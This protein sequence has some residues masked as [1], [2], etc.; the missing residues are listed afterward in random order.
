M[1]RKWYRISAKSHKLTFL[2]SLWSRKEHSIGRC[3]LRGNFT[4]G[5]LGMW[6]SVGHGAIFTWS[7]KKHGC[8][9]WQASAPLQSQG[10]ALVLLLSD[11]DSPVK[12]DLFSL[13]WPV[14][15]KEDRSK[16]EVRW[17]SRRPRTHFPA[18]PLW[19]CC[20]NQPS[21]FKSQ[22]TIFRLIWPLNGHLRKPSLGRSMW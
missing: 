11:R 18:F 2:L 20:P 5:C 3:K 10:W 15:G 17:N 7:R 4:S 1:A 6:L 19:S 14:K 8:H 21:F 22:Q 12:V 9:V 16:A 13:W